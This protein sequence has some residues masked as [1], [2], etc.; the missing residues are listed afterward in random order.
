MRALAVVLILVATG[1]SLTLAQSTQRRRRTSDQCRSPQAHRRWQ[2]PR[3]GRQA[4]K[5]P[6]RRRSRLASRGGLLPCGRLPARH[7]PARRRARQAA[8]GFARAAR[9]DASP[10]LGCTLTGRYS[11]SH[12]AARGDARVGPDNLELGYVLG[13]A[14]IQTRQPDGARVAL[15]RTF[16][17]SR[18]RRRPRRRGA[19]DAQARDGAARRGRAE[20][21]A[22]EGSAGSARQLPAR[23]ARALQRPVGRCGCTQRA[24]AGGEPRRRDGALSA[25]RRLPAGVADRRGNGGAAEVAVA[26]PVLQRR[27]TSFSAAFT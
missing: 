24:G 19:D 2:S 5:S 1:S 14:Y 23:P 26:Q 8:G 20:A 18:L 10:R 22:R 7:R 17:P 21:R 12:S 27:R 15:A 11:R 3:G 6:I 13:Q 4:Q 25:R 9:G 16:G